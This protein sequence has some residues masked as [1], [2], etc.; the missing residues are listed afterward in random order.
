MI[1]YLNGTIIEV[2]PP[3]LLLNVAGVGY[4]ISLPLTS[5]LQLGDK[6]SV[7][8]LFIH[9]QVRE[10]AISLYGFSDLMQ[11]SL[12]RKL[13]KVNGIGAKMAIAI[14]SS[15]NPE[16]FIHCIETQNITLLTKLPGI[17]NKTAQRLLLDLKGQIDL[18]SIGTSAASHSSS[19][20]AQITEQA[21]QALLS[22]G[23]KSAEAE[24]LIKQVD[25]TGLEVSQVV[26][27]ALSLS[28]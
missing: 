19:H 14:L 18:D 6:G 3:E 22:L 21:V 20:T 1:G 16:E 4:E 17:G 25:T 8:E 11:R 26:R 10:D 28:R 27:K 7:A 12:F 9:T 5:F 13:L 2:R 24:Q 15:M 23:Y